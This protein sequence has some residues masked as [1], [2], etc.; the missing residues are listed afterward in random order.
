[1]SFPKQAREVDNTSRN[2][3]GNT[4]ESLQDEDQLMGG[5]SSLLCD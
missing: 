2:R 5:W 1:M 4:P 3:K